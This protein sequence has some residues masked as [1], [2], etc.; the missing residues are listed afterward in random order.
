MTEEK[1]F[2]WHLHVNRDEFEQTPQDSEGQGDLL[3]CSSWGRKKW[4]MAQ[5]LNNN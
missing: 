3:C 5:G 4:D 2:G 1:M